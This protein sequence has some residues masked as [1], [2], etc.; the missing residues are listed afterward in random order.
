[1]VR[2]FGENWGAHV[3]DPE[4]Y[5]ETP[6]G[7]ECIQCNKKIEEGDQ[8]LLIPSTFDEDTLPESI[9]HLDCFVSSIGID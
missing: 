9:W 4:L 5:A 3:C 1:M 7:Q 2:W 6:V 8:G